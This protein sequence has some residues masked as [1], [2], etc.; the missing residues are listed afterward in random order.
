MTLHGYRLIEYDALRPWI[1][2]SQ[3]HRTAELPDGVDFDR[4]A[5]QRFP[6]DRF[7]VLPD[8]PPGR[9]PPSPGT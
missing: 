7:R 9:W 2:L 4:W 5:R 3:Q 6:D 8:E 1:V